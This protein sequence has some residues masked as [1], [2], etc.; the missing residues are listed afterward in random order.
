MKTWIIA[1]ALGVALLAAGAS[2]AF[3]QAGSTGG[4]VGKQDKAVS[5]GEEIKAPDRKKPER[6][7]RET[8]ERDGRCGIA[9]I[10]TFRWLDHV[11]R[12]V[13]RAD[14]TAMHATG[15]E[16]TW[17]CAAGAIIAHWRNGGLT[18]LAFLQMAGTCRAPER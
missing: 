18:T 9:G 11:D 8:T 13:F 3:A 5:G 15:G 1:V 14:G 12:V 6:K 16:G 7:L 4:T 10:W 2:G 17:T